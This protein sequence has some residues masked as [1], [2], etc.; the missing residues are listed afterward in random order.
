MRLDMAGVW[1]LNSCWHQYCFGSIWISVKR[2]LC[3]LIVQKPTTPSIDGIDLTHFEIGH[4]YELGS[5]LGGLFLA[6]GWAI[7]APDRAPPAAAAVPGAAA[8]T[9]DDPPNLVRETC[10]PTFDITATA[11][12]FERRRRPRPVRTPRPS[13][14]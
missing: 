10:P 2:L 11:A 13:T 6:E 14:D 5:T 12:D 8:D 1:R 3:L 4:Q 7:P 9:R